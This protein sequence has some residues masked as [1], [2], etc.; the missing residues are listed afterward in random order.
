MLTPL[1]ITQ[2]KAQGLAVNLLSSL[3]L[4]ELVEQNERILSAVRKLGSS[5]QLPFEQRGIVMQLADELSTVEELFQAAGS[6]HENLG[7]SA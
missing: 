3:L 1:E 5:P 4:I 7:I 6:F 2:L